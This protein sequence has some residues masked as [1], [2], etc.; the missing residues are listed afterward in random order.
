MPV[1]NTR[2]AVRAAALA[3]VA[4][5]LALAPAALAADPPL[6][7]VGTNNNIASSTSSATASPNV[8]VDVSTYITVNRAWEALPPGAKPAPKAVTRSARRSAAKAL[9]AHRAKRRALVRAKARGKTRGTVRIAVS[10]RRR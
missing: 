2:T 9:A 1:L 10:A 4:G 8:F 5:A 7:G 3:T 6:Y